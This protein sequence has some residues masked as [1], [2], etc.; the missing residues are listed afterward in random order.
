[1]AYLK[2]KD[3]EQLVRD[4][5]SSAI[6]NTDTKALQA[7]KAKKQREIIIDRLAEENE[8]MKRDISEIK[9]M[10]RQLMGQK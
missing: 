6:L 2:V 7:Y 1:M 8:E 4:I 5:N 9:S 3:E 10:L